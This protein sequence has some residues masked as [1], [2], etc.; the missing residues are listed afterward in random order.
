MLRIGIFYHISASNCYPKRKFADTAP[1]TDGR[2][3]V[4]GGKRKTAAPKDGDLRYG[5]GI[6]D[7]KR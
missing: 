5:I 6:P 4:K 2:K 1:K 3:D 7:Q